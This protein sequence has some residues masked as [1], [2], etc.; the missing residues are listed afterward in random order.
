MNFL[1]RALFLLAD[2]QLLFWRTDGDCFSNLLREAVDKRY[3]KAAY[4][5]ASNGDLPEFYDLFQ[6]AMNNIG[7]SDCRM[8]RS[9]LQEQDLEY[10]WAADIILLAGGAVER[11]W[12]FFEQ[13]GLGA[14]IIKS[15]Y[16]GAVLVGVSAGAIQLGLCGW[17]DANLPDDNPIHTFKLVP[18]IIGVHEEA[19]GWRALKKALRS[20]GG[21]TRG[22]GIPAGGGLIFYDDHSFRPLRYPVHEF[23]LREGAVAHSLLGLKPASQSGRC[24]GGESMEESSEP[25]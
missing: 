11:G 19:G 4:I 5:G 9:G 14:R 7:I 17:P 2:S 20:C 12:R 24:A 22:L 21:T 1:P 23:V 25:Q 3:P 6:A 16:E 13:T 18:F 8:I 15:Y 10:L